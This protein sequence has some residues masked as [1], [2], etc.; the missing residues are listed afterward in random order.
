MKGYGTCGPRNNL[1][2]WNAR[3]RARELPFLKYVSGVWD[4]REMQR[5]PRN[6]NFSPTSRVFDNNTRRPRC[7]ATDAHIIRQGRRR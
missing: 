3:A 5:P 4:V 6:A 1:M 2:A 7:P